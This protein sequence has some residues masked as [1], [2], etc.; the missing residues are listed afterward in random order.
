VRVLKKSGIKRHIARKTVESSEKLD[1]HRWVVEQTPSLEVAKYRRL[2]IRYE[3][4]DDI[5]MVFLL[6]S[7]SLICFNYL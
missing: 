5:H 4:R 1:R 2:R 7:C 6:L 3:R